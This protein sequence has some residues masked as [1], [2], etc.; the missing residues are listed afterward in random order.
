MP[1]NPLK[2]L[3]LL[4]LQLDVESLYFALLGAADVTLSYAAAAG[5]TM[6]R[7]FSFRTAPLG[8]L[9][10]SLSA[11]AQTDAPVGDDT[12]FKPYH[13]NRDQ[14]TLEIPD[15]W[16]VVDQSPFGNAGVIAFYSQ[17][18]EVRL[19]KDPVVAEQQRQAFITMLNGMLSGEIPSFFMDRYKADKGMTCTG[20]DARAL[21]KKLRIYAKS[22]ALG[23]KAKL[24]GEPEVATTP[25]GGCLG[26]RVMMRAN[27]ATGATMHML[28]YSAAVGDTTYDFVLMTEPQY[29]AQNLPWFERVVASVRLTGAS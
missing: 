10:F 27:T 23:K 5:M 22:D 1:Y 12:A 17:P 20:F 4:L 19:D 9:L 29:F 14:F 16:H 8:A 13:G 25:V 6:N 15:G 7:V 11:F 26:I 24:L 18:V 21:K 3:N 28:V 2:K